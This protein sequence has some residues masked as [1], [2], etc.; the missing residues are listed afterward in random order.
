MVAKLLGKPLNS[1]ISPIE[2]EV[3]KERESVEFS[4]GIY[5]WHLKHPET[6]KVYVVVHKAQSVSYS[7]EVL[8]DRQIKI[9]AKRELKQEELQFISD[10]VHLPKSILQYHWKPWEKSTI[11]D[12]KYAIHKSC[13]DTFFNES[14]YVAIFTI[15]NNNKLEF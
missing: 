4:A 15:V 5:C 9:I 10:K 2:I 7:I 3:D 1:I 13:T 8:T 11:L 6:F 12:L 14:I